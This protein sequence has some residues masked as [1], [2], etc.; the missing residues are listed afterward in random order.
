MW[1]TYLSKL[2]LIRNEA[3]HSTQREDLLSL[4]ITKY[5]DALS[6]LKGITKVPPGPSLLNVLQES[7][8]RIRNSE[9]TTIKGTSP[10]ETSARNLA[11]QTAIFLDDARA[12]LLKVVKLGIN[13]DVDTLRVGDMVE[14]SL[15]IHNQGP[16]PI[17][18]LKIMTTPD[19]GNG[20]FDY[21]AENSKVTL[22]LHGPGPKSVGVFTLNV[23]WS[24]SNMNGE[25]V[26][27]SS[28]IALNVIEPS[29]QSVVGQLDLGGSPYVCGD[30]VR[31][32]RNDVFFGREELLDQIRRQIIQSGNVVLLEGNRRSGKSSILWHLEGSKAVPGWMGVYC[33]LQGAEGSSDG[34]GVPTADVFREISTSIAKGLQSLGGETPLPDGTILPP[35]T[36]LGI[37]KACRKGISEEAAFSDFRDYLE[38]ILEKL[39]E[40][41]I[42]L[43]LMLDEFDKLQEGIDRGITSP[44]VLDNIRFLVQT[45]PRFTVIL[46]GSRRL[47]QLREEYWS[48]LFGLGTRFGV[49]FLSPDSARR[50]VME[51]VKGRLTYSQEAVDRAISL[52]ARQPFLLQ[53]LC[54]RIFDIAA[55]LRTRS[56]KLDLVDQAAEALVE[57]NEHFAYLWDYVKFDRRRLILFLC[58]REALIPDP[59]HFG[60]IQEKL[61]SHDVEVDEETL[62]TDLEFL[63]ELE[64]VDL[65]GESSGGHY[66]LTVP[67]MGMWIEKQQDFAA[68]KSKARLETEDQHG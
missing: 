3:L 55:R 44:Q 63:R 2:Q 18:N 17:R 29:V 30:P 26:D 50:L 56:V 37:A 57:D 34:A 61:I 43:L 59:F 39:A 20:E 1:E 9:W 33:N 24:G 41:E 16:L 28:E 51:P 25:Y 23:T 62:V 21:I 64:L 27:G 67:L 53:C 58:H 31:P 52:T 15:Q 8:N 54:N 47:R 40:Y 22:N 65:V 6:G 66:V 10:S 4:Y 19:W 14:L 32:E 60:V 35:G 49:S 68:I 42:G 46:T 38:V 7:A 11:R 45:Y 5:Y 12:A 36:K 48:A 13:A